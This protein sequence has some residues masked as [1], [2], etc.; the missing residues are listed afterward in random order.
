MMQNYVGLSIPAIPKNSDFLAPISENG[1]R[2]FRVRV[3]IVQNV[4]NLC[5]ISWVFPSQIGNNLL[6][7]QRK[8]CDKSAV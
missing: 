6:T 3:Y 8:N 4:P 2:I 7:L 5:Q 1:C